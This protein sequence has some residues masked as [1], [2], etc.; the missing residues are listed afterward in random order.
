MEPAVD[1]TMFYRGLGG[2][3]VTLLRTA[4]C[5]NA[6][7]CMRVCVYHDVLRDASDL[8]RRSTPGVFCVRFYNQAHRL[9]LEKTVVSGAF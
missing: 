1:K 8:D 6:A 4:W 5:T 3:V 7:P 9:G 2:G